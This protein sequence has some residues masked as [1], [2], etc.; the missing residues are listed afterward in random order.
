MRVEVVGEKGE[1][2]RGGGA[3]VYNE[4]GSKHNCLCPEHVAEHRAKHC[5]CGEKRHEFIRGRF[6]RLDAE[7]VEEEEEGYADEGVEEAE[8]AKEHGHVEGPFLGSKFFQEHWGRETERREKR[9]ER[10]EKREMD[11][12]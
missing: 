11:R 7:V 2:N 5:V 9:E 8:K 6:V 12:M 3:E 1:G 10:R 4:G